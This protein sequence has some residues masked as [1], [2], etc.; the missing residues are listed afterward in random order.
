MKNII[1]N[2]IFTC[3]IIGLFMLG[4]WGGNTLE[5]LEVPEKTYN[6]LVELVKLYPDLSNEI[7]DLMKD[8]NKIS[9]HEYTKI[10]IYL[11][12]AKKDT[13]KIKLQKMLGM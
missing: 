2:I 8:D 1:S 3:I 4:I 5:G 9:H 10:E 7:K 12:K 11:N 6:S 13:S